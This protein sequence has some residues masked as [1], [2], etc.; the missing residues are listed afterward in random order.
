MFDTPTS[1]LGPIQKVKERERERI[2]RSPVRNRYQGPP[3]QRGT[4]PEESESNGENLTN[5]VSRHTQCHN[6][7]TGVSTLKVSLKR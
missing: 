1:V 4:S 3:G 5:I 2:T 7:G 6:C